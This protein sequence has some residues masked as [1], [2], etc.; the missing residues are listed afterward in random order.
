MHAQPKLQSCVPFT[1]VTGARVL[2]RHADMRA[3]LTK[4]AAQ[5]LTKITGGAN[6]CQLVS[7]GKGPHIVVPS[8]VQYLCILQ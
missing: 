5:T 4:V 8:H 7:L 1:P 3:A 2:I 6:S